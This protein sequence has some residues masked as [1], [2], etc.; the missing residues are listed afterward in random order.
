MDQRGF[1]ATGLR[2]IVAGAAA[3]DALIAAEATG[4]A[5]RAGTQGPLPL[6]A[7][8]IKSNVNGWGAEVVR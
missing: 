1:L 8:Q 6:H 7:R 3:E 2:S 4:D 5:A